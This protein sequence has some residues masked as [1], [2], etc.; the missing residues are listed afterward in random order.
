MRGVLR[1]D[2]QNPVSDGRTKRA[3]IPCKLKPYPDS[4]GVRDL[5]PRVTGS[6]ISSQRAAVPHTPKDAVLDS[7]EDKPEKPTGKVL[8]TKDPPLFYVKKITQKLTSP[9]DPI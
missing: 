6:R 9:R 5:F 4:S 2:H 3:L 8:E 1:P 7:T